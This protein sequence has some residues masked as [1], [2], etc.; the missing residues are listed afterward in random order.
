MGA[1]VMLLWNAILPSV[2]GC[3]VVN[4]WQAIGL[5]ALS[6]LFLGKIGGGIGARRPNR[7]SNDAEL[8][9]RVKGMTRDQKREY[10]KEYMQKNS[11]N[12]DE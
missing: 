12:A 1:A 10:I 6:R 5:I 7:W 11:D 3:N 2:I 4:Y 9:E 8:R